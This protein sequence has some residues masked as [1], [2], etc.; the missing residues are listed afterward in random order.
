MPK[1]SLQTDYDKVLLDNLELKERVE[2]LEQLLDEYGRHS[3]GCSAP[4]GS[5]LTGY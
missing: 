2:E 5:A 1:G 4:Y 3:E